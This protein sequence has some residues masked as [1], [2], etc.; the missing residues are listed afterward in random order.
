MDYLREECVV[1]LLTPISW[2]DVM[3]G[4]SELV[5]MDYIVFNTATAI[6]G[7]A[8]LVINYND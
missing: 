1:Y 5:R 6:G 7:I 8:S 3:S 2:L 4:G